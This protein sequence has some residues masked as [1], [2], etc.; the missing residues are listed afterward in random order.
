MFPGLSFNLTPTQASDKNPEFT[1][2]RSNFETNGMLYL[3]EKNIASHKYFD[4]NKK[5]ITAKISTLK[6][7]INN[8]SLQQNRSFR[9]SWAIMLS[10]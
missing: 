3:T 1:K 8:L 5:N 2:L 10:L 4:F 9:K 7:S 6:L